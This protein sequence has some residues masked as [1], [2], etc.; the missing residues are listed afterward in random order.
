MSSKHIRTDFNYAYPTAEIAV[1]GPDGAVSILYRDELAKA[2]DPAALRAKLVAEF[3]EKLANPFVAASRGYVDEIIQ[4]RTTRAK[5]IAALASCETKRDRNPPEEAWQ[6]PALTPGSRRQG[7]DRQPR[8]DR[9]ARDPRLPRA[10]LAERGR[11]LGLRS[12]CDARPAGR[13]GRGHLGASPARGELSLDRQGRRGGEETGARFV[14]P[15]YGFLAENEDFAQACEDA[16]LVFVGPR[17]AVIAR[18]GSKTAAARSRDRGRRAR[19]AGTR[20]RS[21]WTRPRRPS[22]RRPRASGIHSS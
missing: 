2:A 6:H 18:M 3:R 9:G 17:P 4:P 13:R 21:R 11:L 19:G 10:G 14:H 20:R 22:R 7:P 8:R 16:G 15:G 12:Q 1:M 5:L